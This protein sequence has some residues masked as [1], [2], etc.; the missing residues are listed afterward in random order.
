MD[1]KS[2]TTICPDCGCPN[3]WH[4]SGCESG[5]L[6]AEE[7]S[8]VRAQVREG[9]RIVREAWANGQRSVQKGSADV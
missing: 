6:T 1:R 7:A 3:G 9:I 5:L 8:E 4:I 2:D